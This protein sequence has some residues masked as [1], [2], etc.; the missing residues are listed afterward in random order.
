[1]VAKNEP[2]KKSAPSGNGV[3]SQAFFTALD[4]VRAVQQQTAA[5]AAQVMIRNTL[6]ACREEAGRTAMKGRE[7][8]LAVA[9]RAKP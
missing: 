8:G 5:R 9:A 6:K 3:V 7:A 1:M 2:S 4:T